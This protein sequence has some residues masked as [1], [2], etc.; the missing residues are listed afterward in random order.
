[1]KYQTRSY[2]CGPA[3]IVNALRLFG[4]EVAEAHVSKLANT[5]VDGTNVRRMKKALRALGCVN[6]STVKTITKMAS[7]VK[8]GIPVIYHIDEEL[9]WVVV[10]GCL[11][12]SFIAFDSQRSVSNTAE[13]GVRILRPESIGY[14]C[15]GIAVDYLKPK[16]A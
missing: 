5:T 4:V 11:G 3:A 7:M 8:N 10:C 14:S 1:M 6:P 13:N 12:E 15:F 16:E 9:H 2:T